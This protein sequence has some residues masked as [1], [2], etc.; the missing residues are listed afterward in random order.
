MSLRRG[1]DFS[2]GKKKKL[3][4]ALWEFSFLKHT[5]LQA[6]GNRLRLHV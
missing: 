5:L 4:L 6:K 3:F 1:G 2:L